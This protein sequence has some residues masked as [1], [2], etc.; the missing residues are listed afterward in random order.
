MLNS[1]LGTVSLRRYEMS[2][3]A[4]L[5][6][7]LDDFEVTKYTSSI[8]FPYSI[9]DAREFLVAARDEKG[10]MVHRAVVFEGQI[11]GGIG[12]GMRQLSEN[13]LGYWVGRDYWGKGIASSAV[14]TFI[15]LLDQLKIS[16][17]IDAQTA[18]SNVASQR[19]L[20]KNGF[21]FSGAGQCQ[22]PARESNSIPSR[23]YVLKRDQ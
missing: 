4:R 7:L 8:P 3:A 23:T 16:G 1:R 9:D 21:V 2:D 22:T 14:S 12:L 15:S 20:E 19:V 10:K 11:A 13:E 17:S 5:V 18:I 6:E